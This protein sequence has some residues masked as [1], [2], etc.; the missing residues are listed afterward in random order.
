MRLKE[1]AF[2]ASL[3]TPLAFVA[4]VAMAS[5]GHKHEHDHHDHGHE[6][7]RQHDAHVHG[8]AALNIAL[9]GDEVHVELDSPAANIVGFEHV[10]SSAADHAALDKAVAMLKKGDDLFQFNSAAG[11]KMEKAMI[12]SAL[13]EGEHEKHAEAHDHHE[14]HGHK[15]HDDHGHEE[16][17]HGKSDH[18]DEHGHD[19]H[20]EEAHSDIAVEY[21]FECAQPAKLSQVVVEVFEAF[22][23]TEKLN[24]QYVI[25]GKQGAMDLNA[26]NHVVK[27]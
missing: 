12:T 20:K 25:N 11:C 26:R 10:P 19:E 18:H 2:T 3:L 9:D 6:E 14:E 4:P 5:E 21:H 16:R 27:F 15:G 23:R 1:L 22:P 17:G 13:L 7:H 24:V 8:I